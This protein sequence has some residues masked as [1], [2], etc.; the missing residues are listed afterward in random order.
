MVKR[1]S[2]AAGIG[3][4]LVWQTIKEMEETHAVKSPPRK[5]NRKI[6]FDE[7]LAELCGILTTGCGIILILNDNKASLP[8]RITAF[9]IVTFIVSFFGACG[10]I[11]KNSKQLI[12]LCLYVCVSLFLWEQLR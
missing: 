7:G 8:A 3:L 10:V 11:R 2:E 9:G 6:L 12:A 1:V 5:R 4:T